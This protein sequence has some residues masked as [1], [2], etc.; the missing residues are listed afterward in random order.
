[1]L[2]QAHEADHAADGRVSKGEMVMVWNQGYGQ[3]LLILCQ[4][5]E[6]GGSLRRMGQLGEARK[7]PV[8]WACCMV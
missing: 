3:D 7:W 6:D 5:Y 1:M 2:L 8:F 4:A